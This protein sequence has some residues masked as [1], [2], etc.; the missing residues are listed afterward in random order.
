MSIA[1]LCG[2]LYGAL[3]A[4][5]LFCLPAN[6]V[7]NSLLAALIAVL[8]LYTAPYII[9]Y[10]GYYDAYPWLSFAPYN[11]TLVVGPLLYLYLNAVRDGTWKIGWWWLLHLLPACFQLSYYSYVFAQP[12]AFKYAWDA[13]IHRPYIAPAETGWL[14]ASLLAYLLLAWRGDRQSRDGAEWERNFLIAMGLTTTFWLMLIGAEWAWS[15]L[16]Y[17]QRFPFYLWLAILICYLGTAGYA[18]S[19]ARSVA[20]APKA[21]LPE[22]PQPAASPRPPSREIISTAANFAALGKDWHSTIIEARWW[23]DPDLTVATL[24]R[25]LGTNTTTLSRALNEG[26]GFNFNEMINRLR[27]DAVVV[28]L[29]RQNEKAVLDIALAEGFNSKASFNR[30]FK[31]YTGE[32]PTEYRRRIHNSEV[33]TS[34]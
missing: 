9:G 10:A 31:L 33:S 19:V 30:A 21:S 20:P 32:T 12:L 18:D 26:L 27:V 11:L 3:R 8:A 25:R 28:A 22:E 16:N 1:L 5:M 29:S 14:L 6:R 15:G 4:A 7:A 23:R 24:A 13:N 2:V 17:F 34:A